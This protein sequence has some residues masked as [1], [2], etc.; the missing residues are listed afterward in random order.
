MTQALQ[1]IAWA[2][3]IGLDLLVISALLRGSYRQYRLVLAYT[4]ALLL[5]TVVEIAAATAPRAVPLDV[6]YWIDEGVLDVLVF[7]VVIGFIYQ[8][9]EDSRRRP[10]KR[11]WLI[12]G[13]ALIVAVSLALRSGPGHFNH[14]MTLVSRDLNI[15]AVV[16]D[17]ILWSVL[18]TSR[19]PDRRLLLLSGGLGIQLTGAIMGES[20]R[21]LSRRAVLPGTLLEVLTGFLGLYI[22]WRAFRNTPAPRRS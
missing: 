14:R 9:G 13:A 6:F 3:G 19:Q 22:W 4:A 11:R 16:L 2:A 8:A 5:A 15:C 20:L 1:Y 10:V 18:V 21:Q 17:L 7:C 12:A